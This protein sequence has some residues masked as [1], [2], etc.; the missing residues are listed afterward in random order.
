MADI[1]IEIHLKEDNELYTVDGQDIESLTSLSQT[2]SNPETIFYGQQ[3]NTGNLSVLDDGNVIKQFIEDE[4]IESAGCRIDIYANGS[5][6][7]SHITDNSDYD[8]SILTTSLT[9]DLPNSSDIIYSGY[10]NSGKLIDISAV[11]LLQ[12]I[13]ERLGV[14]NSMPIMKTVLPLND[15]NTITIYDYLNSIT[16][17]SIDLDLENSNIYDILESFCRATQLNLVVSC[18]NK[19]F[20]N[21]RPIISDAETADFY[22][23]PILVEDKYIMEKGKISLFINNKIKQVNSKIK[24]YQEKYRQIRF[25]LPDYND[26]EDKSAYLDAKSFTSLKDLYP[27]SDYI[28]ETSS[29][30]VYI[31][32]VK[33]EEYIY[34]DLSANSYKIFFKNA[35]T[36]GVPL[37]T[38]KSVE[39]FNSVDDFITAVNGLDETI[40]FYCGFFQS[41]F[42]EYTNSYKIIY[43]IPKDNNF[44]PTTGWIAGTPKDSSL[45]LPSA[46][47]NLKTKIQKIRTSGDTLASKKSVFN[48]DDDL[49]LTEDSTISVYGKDIPLIDYVVNNILIDYKNGIK[50]KTIK[51]ACGDLYYTDDPD[52]IAKDWSKGEVLNLGDVINLTKDTYRNGKLINW[53]ITGREFIFDGEPLL[54]LELQECLPTTRLYNYLEETSWSRIAELSESGKAGDLFSVGD[55]K[56]IP[57]LG[58]SVVLLGINHDRKENGVVAGLTFG[59][60]YNQ[61]ATGAYCSMNYVQDEYGNPYNSNANGWKDSTARAYLNGDFMNYLPEELRNAIIPVKKLTGAGGGSSTIVETIDKIW[62]PS[63]VEMS[64]S[65]QYSA[66]GEGTQYEYF[67][68]YENGNRNWKKYYGP[69]R[70]PNVSLLTNYIQNPSTGASELTTATNSYLFVNGSIGAID[71]AFSYDQIICFCL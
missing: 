8:D 39:N 36:F 34:Q 71:S 6:I 15:T 61:T 26:A 11:N 69:L 17:R 47:W 18:G 66:S 13:F 57:E 3:S 42:E 60:K 29:M 2:N 67:G 64:G 10:A 12:I 16:F 28:A 32:D 65:T 51:I 37:P 7:Q 25:V 44:A 31:K 14:N 33:S 62:I 22:N 20:F 27:D 35:L 30:Y 1:K 54:R 70:S 50:T 5:L 9:D 23:K 49:L 43:A 53:K 56:Y 46:R 59:L 45:A 68:T 40:R 41:T 21:A 24:G 52:T 4:Q 48:I 19:E 63:E 38:E 58:A 55:E